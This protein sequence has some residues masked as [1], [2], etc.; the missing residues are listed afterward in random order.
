MSTVHGITYTMFRNPH[1]YGIL[2]IRLFIN[3]VIF[4]VLYRNFRNGTET[5]TPVIRNTTEKQ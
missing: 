2:K 3:P 5:G 1:K 4:M